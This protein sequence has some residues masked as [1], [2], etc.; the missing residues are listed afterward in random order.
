[1]SDIDNSTT[2]RPVLTKDEQAAH[3]KREERLEFV[4]DFSGVGVVLGAM[5]IFMI[6][7][8]VVTTKLENIRGFAPDAVSEA[9][10]GWLAWLQP[11]ADTVFDNWGWTLL[12]VAALTIVSAIVH[13]K[14]GAGRGF[15]GRF[16]MYR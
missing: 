13:V 8:V 4:A 16:S 3:A 12:G 9:P 7:V 1:M 14:V 5:I 2:H 6:V 10:P 15:W 11:I